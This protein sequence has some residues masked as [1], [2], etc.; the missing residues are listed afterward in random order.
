MRVCVLY[1]C[2]YT[3]AFSFFDAHIFLFFFDSYH[4]QETAT[5]EAVNQLMLPVFSAGLALHHPGPYALRMLQ[6]LGYSICTHIPTICVKI[7]RR[8]NF[9]MENHAL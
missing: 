1:M 5:L 2:S 9:G 3:L 7:F 4:L 6:T 8:V